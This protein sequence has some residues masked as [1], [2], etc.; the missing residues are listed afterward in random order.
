[1]RK[2]LALCLGAFLALAPIP[3]FAAIT[4]IVGSGTGGSIG[5]NSFSSTSTL[6]IV[7]NT[8]IPAN[9]AVAVIAGSCATGAAASFAVADTHGNTYTGPRAAD[10][11]NGATVQVLYSYTGTQINSGD[12]ITVTL[13]GTTGCLTGQVIAFSGASP[14]PFDVATGAANAGGTG[15]LTVGP[16]ATLACPGGAAGCEVLVGGVVLHVAE[17]TTNDANFTSL[18][19][20]GAGQTWINGF[21]IVGTNA[22]R[23][24]APSISGG[25]ANWAGQLIA[26]K[27]ATGATPVCKRSLL[28]VGC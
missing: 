26:L 27:A 14:T 15:T 18:T 9:S 21:W 11:A 20:T 12:T 4:Q 22:A 13:T 3:A 8:T 28:G 19:A 17:T 1:M 10:N 25:S 24:Y 2:Y 16:T 7:T 23:S 5:G 6:G